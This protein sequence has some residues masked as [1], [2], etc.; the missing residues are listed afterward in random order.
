MCPLVLSVMQSCLRKDK[1]KHYGFSSVLEM[2][3]IDSPDIGCCTIR[4]QQRMAYEIPGKFAINW[5]NILK[6]LLPGIFY[7]IPWVRPGFL[8]NS[9][10][11]YIPLKFIT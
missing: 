3:P 11:P 7:A 10:L 9:Q 8:E 6:F 4:P 1:T 5:H 2:M